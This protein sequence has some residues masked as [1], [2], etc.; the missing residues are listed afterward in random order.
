MTEIELKAWVDDRE[1]VIKKINAFAKYHGAVSKDDTYW[2]KIGFPKIR[3]RKE[4]KDDGCETVFL[5]YKRKEK[6]DVNGTAVEVN[7]EKECEISDSVPLETFLED[8]GFS[9]VLKKHK[10]VLSWTLDLSKSGLVS[11]NL[12]LTIELCNVFPLG[13]FLELEILSPSADENS[14]CELKKALEYYLE[15]SGI[16]GTK[17]EPRYYSELLALHESNLTQNGKA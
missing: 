2:G 5:T 16:P 1:S 12:N 17:I 9:P 10:E 11:Q 6:K 8:S 14:V 13:D 4:K 7:D 15:K 3:I